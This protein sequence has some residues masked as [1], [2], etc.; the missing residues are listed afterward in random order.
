MAAYALTAFAGAIGLQLVAVKEYAAL[1]TGQDTLGRLLVQE[2]PQDPEE[3]PGC[4][5]AD[6]H[7]SPPWGRPVQAMHIAGVPQYI[8]GPDWDGLPTR[9]VLQEG[10]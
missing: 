1:W 7:L 6:N 2:P 4:V 10:Q 5:A 8:D 9:F 3:T